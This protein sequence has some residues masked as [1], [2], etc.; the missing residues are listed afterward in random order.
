MK[1]INLYRYTK[2]NGAVI[3]SPNK[4]EGAHTTLYRL[5]ADID[6]VLTKDNTNFYYMID[7]DTIS[8]WVEV[9]GQIHEV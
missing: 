1:V 2:E 9:E 8:E 6:K 3:V 7:T 5:V 4:P